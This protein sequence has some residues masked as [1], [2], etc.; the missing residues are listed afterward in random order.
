MTTVKE[1]TDCESL[2]PPLGSLPQT[3]KLVVWGKLPR[4]GKIESGRPFFYGL[5]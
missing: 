5:A 1:H 4:E 3:T 2:P